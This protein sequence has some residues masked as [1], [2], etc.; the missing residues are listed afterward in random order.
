MNINLNQ[1]HQA[2]QDAAKNVKRAITVIY[3]GG[4]LFA[5]AMFLSFVSSAFTSAFV[6]LFASVGAILVGV[7][8]I[9]FLYAKEH[10]LA[11][12][13]H[14]GLGKVF[15]AC[16][17]VIL[18]LNTL[19]SFDVSGTLDAQAVPVLN[20]ILK[21]WRVLSPATPILVVGMWAILRAISPEMELQKSQ[22]K[23]MARLIKAHSKFLENEALN[24]EEAK[25]ILRNAAR[26]LTLNN[27]R[28]I[29][30]TNVQSDNYGSREAI[31]EAMRV[32]AGNGKSPKG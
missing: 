28:M 26:E 16:D 27:A 31:E 7:S 24:S 19:V 20:D 11:D 3:V 13:L 2:S 23:Q 8:S 17:L 14:E 32:I 18:A 4:V 12:G 22:N 1:D 5:E 30:G 15:W 21:V 25:D 6:A 9:V 29:T 10:W